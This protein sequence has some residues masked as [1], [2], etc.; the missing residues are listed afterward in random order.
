[1]VFPLLAALPLLLGAGPAARTSTQAIEIVQGKSATV[2]VPFNLG[3]GA[4]SNP[5]VIQAVP[6]VAARRIVFFG[7]KLGNASYT[8]FDAKSK[9]HSI[10]Y[11]IRVVSANLAEVAGNIRQIVPEGIVV[12]VAGDRILVE[13]EVVTA[14]EM[15][16]VKAA[17]DGR[18]DNVKNLVRYSDAATKAAAKTIEQQI[19]DR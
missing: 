7:R 3:A 8:V 17:V 1:M 2:S 18:G 10:E 6:D 13:G 4:N 14:D 19:N 5:E 16:R 12:T 11:E 15:D 9:K